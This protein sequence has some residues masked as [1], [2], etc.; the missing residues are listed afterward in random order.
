MVVLVV[1]AGYFAVP[2]QGKTFSTALQVPGARI[3]ETASGAC[4]GRDPD[5]PRVDYFAGAS[6]LDPWVHVVHL[7]A[8]ERDL[9]LWNPYQG[10]GAPLAGNMQSS[11]FDPFLFALHVHPTA[12]VEDLT[13]L[14]GLM[15][16]GAAAYFAGAHAPTRRARG[17]ADRQRVR[18]VRMVLRL[19]ERRVVSHL[20]VSPAPAGV[21]GVDHPLTPPAPGRAA[22]PLGRRDARG[23]HARARLHGDGGD[24][25]VRARPDLRGGALG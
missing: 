4:V 2:F 16:I 14:I 19:F 12:L 18:A 20:Y 15:L 1:L 11:A 9:P 6:A 24:G 17:G 3:C 13:L 7:D 25:R 10:I 8:A 21:R 22:R 23:R 5:D